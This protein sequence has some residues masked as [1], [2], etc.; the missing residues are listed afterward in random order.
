MGTSRLRTPSGRPSHLRDPEGIPITMM[1]TTKK[2]GRPKKVS[3]GWLK[4]RLVNTWFGAKHPS[5]RLRVHVI[6]DPFGRHCTARYSGQ[7]VV[8]QV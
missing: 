2:F 7:P 8:A 5:K 1:A 3:R 4:F 6:R